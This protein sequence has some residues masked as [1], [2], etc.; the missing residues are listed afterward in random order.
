MREDLRGLFN[1]HFPTEIFNNIGASVVK[2]SNSS[3]DSSVSN[4]GSTSNPE[5]SG[6][7]DPGSTEE[8]G[9]SLEPNL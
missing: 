4:P 5:S 9:G 8:G 2:E 1:S 3:A 7:P 6:N